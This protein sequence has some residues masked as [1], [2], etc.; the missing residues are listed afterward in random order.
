MRTELLADD[1]VDALMD[2]LAGLDT[3]LLVVGA[4]DARRAAA[5]LEQC[6]ARLPQMPVLVVY[7][8]AAA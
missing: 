1:S 3:P 4:V 7:R 5:L 2:Y 8:E 6:I